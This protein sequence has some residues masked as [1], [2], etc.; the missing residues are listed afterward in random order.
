MEQ[1]DPWVV[2]EKREN[3]EVQVRLDLQDPW[4]LLDQGEKEVER[5]HLGPLDSE[6][7]MVF[8]DLLESLGKVERQDHLD[9][10]GYQDQREIWEQEDQ[11][12]ALVC[13]DLEVSFNL[14]LC[15]QFR[16]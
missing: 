16:T 7:L 1:R 14:S 2:L 13:K 3:K 11:K 15:I 9:S 10:L 8:P 4:D 6:V 12:E 5:D